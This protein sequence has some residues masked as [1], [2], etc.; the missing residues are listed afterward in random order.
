MKFN[1][2]NEKYYTT[3]FTLQLTAIFVGSF[4]FSDDN[5]VIL[6]ILVN[7][8]T[9][10]GFVSVICFQSMWSVWFKTSYSGEKV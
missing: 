2:Y 6:M 10:V 9:G 3:M 1:T 4:L 7:L 8:N 5:L